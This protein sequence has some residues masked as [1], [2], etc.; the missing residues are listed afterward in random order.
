MDNSN[1]NREGKR[2]AK[3]KLESNL[4]QFESRRQFLQG[5]GKVLK[6]EGVFNHF[7]M[8]P[9]LADGQT[10]CKINMQQCLMGALDSVQKAQVESAAQQ[11][12]PVWAHI[13]RADLVSTVNPTG[14]VLSIVSNTNT[15]CNSTALQEAHQA[16]AIN[17]ST[18][19]LA[20]L[21]P[22]GHVSHNAIIQNTGHV[23]SE[24]TELLTTYAEL[25]IQDCL[26][27]M[28]WLTANGT[29]ISLDEAKKFSSKLL[30]E[31]QINNIGE[32]Y[33][34]GDENDN[35]PVLV[36]YTTTL[37]PDGENG[38]TIDDMLAVTQRNSNDGL[39]G[40]IW[41]V[42]RAK[43]LI[44]NIPA[45]VMLRA[46]RTIESRLSAARMGGYVQ[47]TQANG[48]PEPKFADLEIRPADVGGD[49]S[50]TRGLVG[51]TIAFHFEMF[52][53]TN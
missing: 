23:G 9:Y 26:S 13:M 47:M 8:W 16:G 34:V 37:D 3:N 27:R 22:G 2:L 17:S 45:P 46:I 4:A 10:S 38:L 19:V 33:A 28:R 12:K 29:E 35:V 50:E 6:F 44:W 21:P 11:C 7:S 15:L 40:D 42:K 14:Q 36:E 31:G 49:M 1:L 30:A 18:Q 25:D 5:D 48:E 43:Q 52:V 41:A 24:A 53:P 32:L 39:V 51:A 20:V